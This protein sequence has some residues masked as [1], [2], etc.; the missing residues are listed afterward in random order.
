MAFINT[1]NFLKRLSK[2][3]LH[4]KLKT[5]TIL[6]NDRIERE[7]DIRREQ[8]GLLLYSFVKRVSSFPDKLACSLICKS[9]SHMHLAKH[10][11]VIKIFRTP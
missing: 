11:I 6:Q 7:E 1:Y 2:G 3:H 4:D 5:S 9:I 8:R 10:W